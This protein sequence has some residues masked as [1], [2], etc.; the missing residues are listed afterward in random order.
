MGVVFSRLPLKKFI[1]LVFLVWLGRFF[2]D[3]QGIYLARGGDSARDREM[4][5]H[6]ARR[7]V[8]EEKPSIWLIIA[9]QDPTQHLARSRCLANIY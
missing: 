3:L 2:R 6:R 4:A 9:P 7:S 1:C 8:R 5:R